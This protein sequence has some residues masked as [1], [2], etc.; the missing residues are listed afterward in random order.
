MAARL[1]HPSAPL[2]L[3]AVLSVLSLAVR[4]AWL[5][6]PCRSPCKTE[7]AHTLVVDEIYFVKHARGIAGL[8]PPAGQTYANAPL[9]D[10]PNSEHPQLVK[11]VIAGAIELFG[12]GP[13]AWRIGSLLAGTLGVLGVFVLGRAA[14]GGGWT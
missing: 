7:A 11:L 4:L 14:G 5:G 2:A 6:G 9:G 10:D 8:R 3:L 13:F 12:D 1:R